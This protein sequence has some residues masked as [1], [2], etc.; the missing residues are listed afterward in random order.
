MDVD[1]CFDDSIFYIVEV[2]VDGAF[3]VFTGVCGGSGGIGI[4]NGEL[5]RANA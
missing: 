2:L 1:R 5:L 4:M 3:V